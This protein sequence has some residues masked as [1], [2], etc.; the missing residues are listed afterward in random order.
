MKKKE[1]EIEK[2]ETLT[3]DNCENAS[4]VIAIDNP[5]W[6]TK[7][8][9]YDPC[10]RFHSIGEGCNSRLLFENEFPFWKIVTYKN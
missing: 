9:E 10:D 3:V 4:T 2:L 1:I 5:E 7:R 8:F 6:G